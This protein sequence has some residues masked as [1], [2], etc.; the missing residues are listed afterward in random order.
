MNVEQRRESA[1]GKAAQ[2]ADTVSL[3]A[4]ALADAGQRL[5][6][7]RTEFQAA[8]AAKL[9]QQKR[10]VKRLRESGRYWMIRARWC[11][12]QALSFCLLSPLGAALGYLFGVTKAVLG[13]FVVAVGIMGL[14]WV[15]AWTI[16]FGL[17]YAAER[18][19]VREIEHL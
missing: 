6:E 17:Y 14:C 2:V 7:A 8:W 9:A 4:E 15:V 12:R 16:G 3:E 13:V 5:D 18:L 1:A 10:R 19:K 11:H